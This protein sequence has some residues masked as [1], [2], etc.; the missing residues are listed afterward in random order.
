[1]S[2]VI[3]TYISGLFTDL[4]QTP[5][6]E[7]ARTEL[8]QMSEDKYQQLRADGSSDAEATGRVITEFGNLDELAD[9]LGIR[10]AV[11]GEETAPLALTE[12][13][14]DTILERSLR[15]ARLVAAGVGI[16]ILGV[17]LLVALVDRGPVP[18]VVGMVGMLVAIASG[19][20]SIIFGASMRRGLERIGSADVRVPAE[21]LPKLRP[22]LERA[23]QRRTIG[24]VAGVALI[25]LGVAFPIVVPLLAPERWVLLGASA[26]LV[27]TAIGVYA[28]VSS[29]MRHGAYETL[30]TPWRTHL[31]QAQ[32][33][34]S[35]SG[36]GGTVAAVYWP[37]AV[38]VFLSWSFIWDAWDRSW[39]VWPIAGVAF[40]VVVLIT[41]Q[42]TLARGTSD[43][44]SG[45]TGRS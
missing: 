27:C 20:G 16:I 18:F 37:V 34:E 30:T 40:P 17:A 11:G 23:E 28:I 7:R 38:L 31:D 2:D 26:L 13:E 6:V 36:P 3:R 12:Q 41:R 42:I 21:I 5:E 8:L 33:D 32:E 24:I 45:R 39:I 25:I 1:M 29:T 19:V 43:T 14:I 22:A 44:T 9:D 10:D 15:G 4:P 35:W